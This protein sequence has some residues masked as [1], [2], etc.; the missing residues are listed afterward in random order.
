MAGF[1]P[2]GFEPTAFE[3]GASV[4]PTVIVYASMLLNLLPPGKVW[5]LV[6]SQLRNLFL[7]SGDEL[8]LLHG[9]V[10]DL[11]AESVPTTLDELLAEA[12][13]ELDLEST[14]TIAERQARVIARLLARQ[15]YRPVDF[16]NALAQLLAQDPVDVVVIERTHAQAITMGDLSGNEI[17]HFFIY[18]DPT[19]P[20]TY[21]LAS[22]QALVNQI[23][24]SH[25]V[26]TVIESIDFLCDSATSLCDRDLLGV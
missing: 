17:F 19:S 9:R 4:E 13:A 18:R 20:G 11:L 16:Q 15:R 22:A 23:K 1:E 6:A 3:E 14:G 26:G 25:T 8:A 7:G 5:R 12:E 10:D 2:T 24:P 21:Y